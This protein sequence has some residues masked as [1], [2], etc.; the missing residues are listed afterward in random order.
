MKSETLKR[1][2]LNVIDM[3]ENRDDLYAAA[4]QLDSN[5]LMFKKLIEWNENN[6]D[7]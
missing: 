4:E 1:L 3:E 7:S 6:E 2:K 5:I